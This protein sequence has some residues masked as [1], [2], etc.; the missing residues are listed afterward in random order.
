MLIFFKDTVDVY[1]FGTKSVRQMDLDMFIATFQKDY[2]LQCGAEH[3]AI[4]K[5]R[6]LHIIEIVVSLDCYLKA[7]NL[8]YEQFVDNEYFSYEA[9]EYLLFLNKK[10]GR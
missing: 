4:N 2:F 9:D 10:G 3:I 6:I 8:P 7:K 1:N 5:Q